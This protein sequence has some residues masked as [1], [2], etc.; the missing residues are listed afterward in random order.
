MLGEFE[1]QLGT[2]N[3][4]EVNSSQNMHTFESQTESSREVISNATPR[5]S[6]ARIRKQMKSLLV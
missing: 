5:I 3:T 6:L 1:P 2:S 4:G